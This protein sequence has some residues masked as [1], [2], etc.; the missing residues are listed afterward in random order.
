[1]FRFKRARTQYLIKRNIAVDTNAHDRTTITRK[2]GNCQTLNKVKQ[3]MKKNLYQ[4]FAKTQQFIAQCRN[5]L[6]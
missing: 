1:M 6:C 3:T 2:I 4:L 5:T